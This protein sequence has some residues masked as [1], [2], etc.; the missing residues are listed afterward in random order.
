MT[1]GA[2][3]WHFRRLGDGGSNEAE[4]VG[5][6][7]DIGNSPLDFG[8]V[9]TDALA[10]GGVGRMVRMLQNTCRPRAVGR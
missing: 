5:M 1:G 8:H 10:A 4:G 3:I 9:A 7:G 2:G 6:D